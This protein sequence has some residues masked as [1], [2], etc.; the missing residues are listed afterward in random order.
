MSWYFW[1]P[2][3]DYG[4]VPASR[5]RTLFSPRTKHAVIP[6]MDAN[7]LNLSKLLSMAMLIA[8]TIEYVE[9]VRRREDWRSVARDRRVFATEGLRALIRVFI[10]D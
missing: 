6:G 9:I 4:W 10:A 7:L 5:S 1:S 8:A 3:V 2:V